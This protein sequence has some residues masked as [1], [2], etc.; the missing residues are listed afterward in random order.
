MKSLV[1]VAAVYFAWLP[2]S[3][4]AQATPVDIVQIWQNFLASQAAAKDCDAI[5]PAT[6]TRFLSNLSA[7][8][9]RAAQALKERNPNLSPETLS[10][11]VKS[12]PSIVSGHV[13]VEIQS[14]GCSSPKILT[15]L[16]VYRMHA[17]MDLYHNR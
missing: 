9:I 8:S 5:D 6:E 13:D 4:M 16:K 15:L 1:T 14:H 10:A 3:A 2:G 12:T 11:Q 7:V 17:A